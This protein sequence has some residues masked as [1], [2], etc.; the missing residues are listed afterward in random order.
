VHIIPPSGDQAFVRFG[1][2]DLYRGGMK[3]HL[4]HGS[5]IYQPSITTNYFGQ[6]A[7]IYEGEFVDGKMHGVGTLN[8]FPFPK[9]YPLNSNLF[10]TELPQQ[11]ESYTYKLYEGQ[12]ADNQF[13]GVG[14]LV[15]KYYQ[16]LRTYSGQW[17][18][19]VFHGRGI[20]TWKES[21]PFY[22]GR[23]LDESYKGSF[24]SGRRHGDGVFTTTIITIWNQNERFNVEGQWSMDVLQLG[25]KVTCGEFTEIC[26]ED[27]D[28]ACKRYSIFNVK[29]LAVVADYIIKTKMYATY[30]LRNL[31]E[32]QASS[33]DNHF[34]RLCNYLRASLSL[35]SNPYFD[36]KH[37]SQKLIL[38]TYLLHNKKRFGDNQYLV[39]KS[40]N[41]EP[42]RK[43]HRYLDSQAVLDRVVTKM[44]NKL[45]H[46]KYYEVVPFKDTDN[47]FIY[48]HQDEVSFGEAV[49]DFDV[50]Q[51]GCLLPSMMSEFVGNICEYLDV[52]D[53]Y[54]MLL[55]CRSMHNLR[56]YWKLI[57]EVLDVSL[58]KPSVAIN[59]LS[60][61]S[62][63]LKSLK[64]SHCFDDTTTLKCFDQIRYVFKVKESESDTAVVVKKRKRGEQ[65]PPANKWFSKLESLDV[66]ESNCSWRSIK[67]LLTPS[68]KELNSDINQLFNLEELNITAPN[69]CKLRL[70]MKYAKVFSPFSSFL[71]LEVLTLV[72]KWVLNLFD[73][74][75]VFPKLKHITLVNLYSQEFVDKV[76]NWTT[77]SFP[78]R[79]F[80]ALES[81]TYFEKEGIELTGEEDLNF[82]GDVRVARRY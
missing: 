13:D 56:F 28:Y 49:E 54:R 74:D 70:D 14:K 73:V 79:H 15:F 2:G 67:N 21:L 35:D 29:N 46:V 60:I 71:N 61:G 55:T 63:H 39:E 51:P 8:A 58:Q 17:K 12:F 48:P 78:H 9:A 11:E 3:N 72:G 52:E 5:G 44:R 69:L 6:S 50:S 38:R 23:L 4:P 36:R 65:G 80:P 64:L 66:T 42:M 30:K 41:D 59:M 45:F 75:A 26:G 77:T 57:P 53:K 47:D 32:I 1:N 81:V 25:A 37:R 43:T 40:L 76:G 22:D 16:K 7:Y 20:S 10:Y 34:L 68:L 82:F 31:D 18:R 19:G 27:Y 33:V 62:H 24:D